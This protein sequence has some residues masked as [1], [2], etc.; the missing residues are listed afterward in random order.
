LKKGHAK[1]YTGNAKDD[2]NTGEWGHDVQP[3]GLYVFR[4]MALTRWARFMDPWSLHKVAGHRDMAITKRY[5]HPSDESVR[6][7]IEKAREPQGSTRIRHTDENTTESAT[8][9]SPASRLN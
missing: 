7:A 5:V 8:R 6:E 9:V 2:P 4:H 1:A 3:F